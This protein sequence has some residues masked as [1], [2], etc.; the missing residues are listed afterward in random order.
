MTIAI[1]LVSTIKEESN[2]YLEEGEPRIKFLIVQ[3]TC[4]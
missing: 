2:L 4:D 1:Q 3:L